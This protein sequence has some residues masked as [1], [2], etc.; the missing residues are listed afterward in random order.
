MRYLLP[1]VF[2]ALTTIAL[3]AQTPSIKALRA[4]AQENGIPPKE[5]IFKLF[6]TSDI[7]VLGEQMGLSTMH[8]SMTM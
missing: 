7:V 2:C 4:C 1:F 5:Y 3:K 6:E 8:L